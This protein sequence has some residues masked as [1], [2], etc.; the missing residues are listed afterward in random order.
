MGPE[1]SANVLGSRIATVSGHLVNLSDQVR[2]DARSHDIFHHGEVFQIFVSL[3]QG[4]ASKEL[5]QDTSNT[6]N[7]ARI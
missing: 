4:I 3:E 6:P 1:E 2:V 7:V 5:N